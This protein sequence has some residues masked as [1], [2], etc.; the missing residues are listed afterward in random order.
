MRSTHCRGNTFDPRFFFSVTH[1]RELIPGLVPGMTACM[2]DGAPAMRPGRS[3]HTQVAGFPM[4]ADN[5]IPDILAN[6]WDWRATV[7]T[8][9][10]RTSPQTH[11]KAEWGSP[12]FGIHLLQTGKY[13]KIWFAENP[14]IVQIS[15]SFFS[16]V[17]AEILEV[18]FCPPQICAI[19]T[20]YSVDLFI[21][22]RRPLVNLQCNQHVTMIY[23]MFSVTTDFYLNDSPAKQ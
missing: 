7:S 17:G 22:G 20:H 5:W 18:S 19:S 16:L 12:L 8:S 14:A 9:K 4:P 2:L 15:M 10:R 13:A 6:V 3:S 21:F 11:W 23:V 1:T